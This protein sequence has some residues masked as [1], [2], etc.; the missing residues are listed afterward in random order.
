MFAL[1]KIHKA[2]DPLREVVS[3]RGDVQQPA[4]KAIDKALQ[5]LI[6]GYKRYIRDSGHAIW[7]LQGIQ[8]CLTNARVNWD[9]IYIVSFDIV[10]FFPS[11]DYDLALNSWDRFSQDLPFE[12]RIIDSLRDILEFQLKN[13]YV[14]FNGKFY[15]QL[16]GLPIGTLSSPRDAE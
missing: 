16:S 6:Q 12:G 4:A 5:P 10:P 9:N 3:T 8:D 13:A 11:I 1:M 15:H 2:G 7:V 14:Q